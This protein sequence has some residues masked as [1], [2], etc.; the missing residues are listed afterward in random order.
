LPQP[1]AR[2]RLPLATAKV[3]YTSGTTGKPKGVCL[4]QRALDY[5][6]Q[7][8]WTATADLGLAKHLCLLPLATLLENVAGVYAPLRNGA[9][10]AV[11]SLRDVGWMGSTGLD[12]RSFVACIAAHRPHSVIL[13]PQ[14]LAALVGACEA[15]APLPGSLRF[16]A[17]GGAR[18]PAALLERAARLG[19]PAYE[20]YGLTECASVVALN[21]P[22]AHR[23]GSAGR[24]LPH[25][26]IRIDERSEIHVAGAATSCYVG[27]HGGAAEEIAT[28]D[29]GKID[30]DGYLY[31]TGR[32]K[33]VFITSFGRNVSPDWV[34]AELAR[35]APIGQAALFGEGRPWNVAVLVPT[36]ADASTRDIQRAVD[37]V[38]AELPDYARAH[39]WIRADEPFTP[40]NGL[41]TPNGRNRRAALLNR[42]GTR[43]DAC[44]YDTL[45][46]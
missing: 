38:N 4:T 3:S 42:Y 14:T 11:P 19:L 9:E 40:A 5:V 44:Y 46:I 6:A 34:E 45:T 18:V 20:G 12:V 43:I 41:A 25:A 27:E 23:A 35:A 37:T 36:R 29:L 24:V 31:V 8:L 1:R 30:A 33:N 22:S 16:A 13:L 21:T 15:G 26:A 32:R 10:I 17:V 7:S 28:G 39:D 2:R